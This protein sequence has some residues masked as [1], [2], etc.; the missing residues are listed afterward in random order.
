MSPGLIWATDRWTLNYASLKIKEKKKWWVDTLYWRVFTKTTPAPHKL[1]SDFITKRIGPPQLRE[2]DCVGNAH[3]HMGQLYFCAICIWNQHGV[4]H[5]GSF[6]WMNLFHCITCTEELWH[7]PKH[8]RLWRVWGGGG[9]MPTASAD[10][11]LWDDN[12]TSCFSGGRFN[13]NA[14]DMAEIHSSSLPVCGNTQS[15]VTVGSTL[16]QVSPPHLHEPPHLVLILYILL[17]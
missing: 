17:S 16:V 7:A 4:C 6:W 8:G 1:Y 13:N 11:M 9:S 3:I 2:T 14:C 5:F 15:V 10:E 12:T